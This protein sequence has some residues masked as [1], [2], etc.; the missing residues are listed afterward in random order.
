MFNWQRG[1]SAHF[2]GSLAI[3]VDYCPSSS[4]PTISTRTLSSVVLIIGSIRRP[5]LRRHHVI[6]LSFG[7]LNRTL[8]KER[9]LL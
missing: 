3:V 1:F 5:C 8:K 7:I 9:R 4:G 2:F 6:V